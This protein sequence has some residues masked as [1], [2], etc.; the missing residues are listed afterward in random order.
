MCE[1]AADHQPQERHIEDCQAD[2]APMAS[3]PIATP[4]DNKLAAMTPSRAQFFME[5]FRK[6]EKLL[7]PNEQAAV[8]YVIA[9]P[10]AASQP[11]SIEASEAA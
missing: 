10:E 9:M 6:E 3:Q 2:S 4:A 11:A 5:R 7:G 8:A 1:H